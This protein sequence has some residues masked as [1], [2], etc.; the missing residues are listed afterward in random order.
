MEKVVLLNKIPSDI[1]DLSPDFQRIYF[2][3]EFCDF[4]VPSMAEIRKLKQVE[5]KQ[6]V[7]FSIVTPYINERR[8]KHWLVLLSALDADYPGT[9]VIVNDWGIVFA[10][11]NQFPRLSMVL[12]R[13]LS[14]QKRGFFTLDR[15]ESPEKV[16]L[17]REKEKDYAHSSILQNRYLCDFLSKLTI[18]R[19]GLDNIAAPLQYFS[20]SRFMIDLYYPYIYLTTSNYCL[21]Y[22]DEKR[23]GRYTKPEHCKAYCNQE[24]AVR[25]IRAGEECIY[26]KG[27]T[28]FRFNDVVTKK[29]RKNDRLVYCSL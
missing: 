21:L 11:K 8:L 16:V 13:V 7:P 26:L 29:F 12:G 17:R 15:Y 9:E 22:V 10:I 28:Q 1:K 2:G 27:N 25:E 18:D 24:W 20:S 14:K 19:M 4:L 23:C 5:R 3:S 6:R